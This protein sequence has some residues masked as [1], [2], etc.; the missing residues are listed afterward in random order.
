MVEEKEEYLY[1]KST[2]L[3]VSVLR[4]KEPVR[5]SPQ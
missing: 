2:N 4:F 3:E 5:Y 1:L